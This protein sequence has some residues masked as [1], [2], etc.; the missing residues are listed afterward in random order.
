MWIADLE[1]FLSA[2][3]TTP[4]IDEWADAA[5]SGWKE[6]LTP[7]EWVD[8]GMDENQLEQMYRGF[9]VSLREKALTQ[10]PNG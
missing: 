6:E 4:T 10:H 2:S 5:I 7:E 1:P 9:A 8:I 3:W